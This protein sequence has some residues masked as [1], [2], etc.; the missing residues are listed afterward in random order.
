MDI[1][2]IKAGMKVRLLGKHSYEDSYDNIEDFYKDCQ[3]SERIQKMKE[4]GYG[5]VIAL[6][7]D[8]KVIVNNEYNSFISG[9]LFSSSDLE[10]YEEEQNQQKNN[11][12]SPKEW[13]LTPMAVCTVRSGGKFVTLSNERSPML[14][15]EDNWSRDLKDEYDEKL[16]YIFDYKNSESICDIVKIEYNGQVVWERKE[17]KYYT[18]LEA[19]RAG[20][21]I[22]YKGW[23]NFLDAQ[24]VLN[25]TYVQQKEFVIEIINEKVWQVE[26]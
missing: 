2:D 22:K 13:L 24:E 9:W 17:E 12:K 3:N 8:K 5:I 18:L 4:Q 6:G 21:K 20:K 16:S 19:I 15:C 11:T 25:W 23:Q 26:G 7:A 10:P 1:K 14:E